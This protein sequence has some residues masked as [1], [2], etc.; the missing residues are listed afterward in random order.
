[1]QQ[2][3]L[4]VGWHWEPIITVPWQEFVIVSW[5][6][7]RGERCV[8]QAILDFES[9]DVGNDFINQLSGPPRCF[10]RET[11]DGDILEISP[12]HWMPLPE[13]PK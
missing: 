9:I 8:S 4:E 7:E 13:P 2:R 3:Q 6:S 10:W 11:V 1:M 12:T 5:I